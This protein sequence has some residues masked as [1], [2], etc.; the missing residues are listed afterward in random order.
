MIESCD[1]CFAVFDTDLWSWCIFKN[2]F[3]ETSTVLCSQCAAEIFR[4]CDESNLDLVE[5]EKI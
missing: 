1:Y 3:D 4:N 2:D 5:Y